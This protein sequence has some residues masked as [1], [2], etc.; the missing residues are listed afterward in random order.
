MENQLIPG[1]VSVTFRQMTPHA[2]IDLVQ[3]SGLKAIEWGSDV[4]VKA[5]DFDVAS[6]VRIE[7]E[8][9]GIIP[10]SYGSYYGKGEAGYDTFSKLVETAEALKTD[11]IRIWA[12]AKNSEDVTADERRVYVGEVQTL[13]DMAKKKG[14]DISFECHNSTLTNN[15]DSAVRLIE[16]IARDNF[17]LYWQPLGSHGVDENLSIIKKFMP[18][19]KNVHVYAWKE[20]ERFPLAEHETAWRK[21]I[22]VLRDCKGTHALLLEF[23][24]D[25]SIEQLRRDAETLLEWL[26]K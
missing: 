24:K 17:Y 22:D 7:S 3:K 16:E 25:D 19:L 13:A 15:P 14:I 12:G 20:L 21:Y 10:V 8:K 5:G 6:N 9:C 26:E 1:M 23:V 2:I 11:N 4:H 18:Y